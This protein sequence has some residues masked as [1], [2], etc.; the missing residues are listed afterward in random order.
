MSY[1]DEKEYQQRIKRITPQ[2]D[3]I[4]FSR[5]APIGNVG[6][7]PG[8]FICCQGQR[9]VLLRPKTEIVIPRY[10]LY[11]LQG[12]MVKD[13][14]Y[15]IEK[16]GSTVSN[17]N[18]SDLRRLRLSIPAIPTQMIIVNKLDTFSNLCVDIVAGLPAEIAAR[19][20]QYEYYRDKLLTFKGIA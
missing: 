17:F 16:I 18:I 12:S 1:V 10:L 3:D 15:K 6:I 9:V 4:L 20:K 14:I 13:Q 19:Q 11:A 2:K 5:E 7:I 8:N